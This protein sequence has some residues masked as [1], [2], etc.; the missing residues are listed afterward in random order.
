M[1]EYKHWR[2]ELDSDNILWVI[3]DR[4]DK[5]VNALNSEVLDELNS[6]IDQI[7]QQSPKGV[8]FAS[9]K[10]N[11][12]IAGADIERFPELANINQAITFLRQGQ[13]VF[14]KLEAISVPTV[15]M[16]NGFCM[17]GGCEL[18]LACDY[19]VALEDDKTKIGLP[20]V[21]LG[22]Y[23]SWGGSVRLTRLVGAIKAMSIILPGSA[24][25]S[26]AARNIGFVD[27][28]VPM[29]HLK[30]AAKS[31]ILNR[32][33]KH[34]P[35]FIE[36]LTNWGPI[37]PL[38]AKMFYKQLERKVNKRHYPAPFVV[39]RN[40]VREGAPWG[41]RAAEEAFITEAN[42]AG[43]LAVNDTTR[44][45]VRVFFLQNKMKALAK[46]S[47]KK[48]KHVHVI[49]A[50]TM[51]GDI[52]AWCA[53]QGY[54]VT[55]QD[56]EPKFIAPA[57]ARAFQ[58]YKKKLK[59]P[60]PI[61]EVMD[62]LIP[63]PAGYGVKKAD[64]I[65]EAIFEDLKVKQDLFK[66]LE[67]ESKP[68]AVLA[69][70][71]SSIPLDDISSVMQH[72]G[73]LVGIHFFNPV[74]MMPLVEV[75]RS[76]KTEDAVMELALSFVVKIGK[77]P[78]AVKS[79]PGFL[80]NR[81]L[82]PYMM[83]AMMLLE[84]GVSGPTIDKAA[85]DFGMPMGPIELADVVGLDVCLHVSK[86]LVDAFG[87]TVPQKLVDMV[88]KKQLGKKTGQGFYDYKNGKPVKSAPGAVTKE[89]TDR[90]IFRM[91]NETAA[92]LR[93]GVI[94]DTEL[95]DA[96]MIFGTGFAPFRGGPMQYAKNYGIASVISRF[97]E[98]EQKFGA[99]FKPDSQWDKIV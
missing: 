23:P 99:R 21:K 89:M 45:L 70:N 6:L 25:R 90:M 49:G 95:L 59:K 88:A 36:R 46:S 28:V 94:D 5:S 66:K 24:V 35:S 64:L 26:S 82:L 92:C 9:G 93:E 18:A 98:L 15:A 32:V 22:I 69:S 30:V 86:N 54:T 85:K 91:L 78:V 42:G 33:K 61:Q 97:K 76:Q 40:W 83:E 51:G 55:L 81:C 34:R 56:R 74:A 7:P 96:G 75:V 79:H 17:G 41:R 20:E 27:E 38:L 37:R 80:V 44:N 58:A 73:R 77:F 47:S 19:R 87:G 13:K 68:D 84:E 53:L 67:Q 10:D 48:I 52:A 63:D 43:E 72:P 2:T 3:F 29:R 1:K 71:T 57:I 16:I 11:G 12:F 50:G 39:V 8:I 4:A 60:R 31:M 14:S 65:I 62:R